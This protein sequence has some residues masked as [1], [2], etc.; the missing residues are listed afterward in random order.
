MGLKNTISEDNVYKLVIHTD[1]VYKEFTEAMGNEELEMGYMDIFIL[2]ILVFYPVL[3]AEL[4]VYLEKQEKELILSD[5]IML[6]T[7]I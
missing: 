4:S 2:T 7:E 6:I 5:L 3:A 1:R